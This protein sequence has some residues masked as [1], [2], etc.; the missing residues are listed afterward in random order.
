MAVHRPA[1]Q[2]AAAHPL[3]SAVI[4]GARTPEQVQ[5]NVQSMQIAIPGEFWEALKREQLIAPNA[6]VPAQ[7]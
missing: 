5:A 3:V 1:L 6:P 4:P 2:F 7:A